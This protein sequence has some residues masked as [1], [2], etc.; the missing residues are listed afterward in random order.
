MCDDIQFPELNCD[1]QEGWPC[2]NDDD[3]CLT[4]VSDVLDFLDG[5]GSMTWYPK[6]YPDTSGSFTFSFDRAAGEV[7]WNGSTISVTEGTSVPELTGG[8]MTWKVPYSSHLGG[9]IADNPG[10][11][12]KWTDGTKVASRYLV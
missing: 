12:V 4:L 5:L 8:G 7:T 11:Q 2:P 1:E 6:P 3:D 10:V 9:F